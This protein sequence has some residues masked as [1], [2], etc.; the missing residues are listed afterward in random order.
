MAEA[1]VSLVLEQLAS[2]LVAHTDAEVKLV[3]GVKDEVKKLTSNFRAIKAVLEDAENRQVKENSVTEWLE[4]LKDASYEIEDVLNEWN[5]EIQKLQMKI[6]EDENA[7]DA[8]KK[9]VCSLIPCYRFS[10]RHIVKRRDIAN[11]FRNLNMTLDN[12]AR[13]KDEFRFSL[14]ESTRRLE[15]P[16][17]TS[18]TDLSKVHGRDQ[19]KNKIV[20]LLLSESS[21]GVDS[22]P[23]ISLVGMGG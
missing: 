9:K 3:V 7:S 4:N 18:F 5:T 19:D 14:A 6:G 17:T 20:D 21:Q 12:N 2:I 13:M 11:K 8:Q 1:L 22:L 23:L 15:Q 16:K 10:P